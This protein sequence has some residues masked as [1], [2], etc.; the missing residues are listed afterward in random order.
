M[1]EP[2]KNY[3]SFLWRVKIFVCF[4]FHNIF[5]FQA[6]YCEELGIVN[7]PD[8]NELDNLDLDKDGIL[9]LEEANNY[10]LVSFLRIGFGFPYF[11]RSANSA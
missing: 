9:E 10:K 8:E 1:I 2:P 4:I 7:C 6:Q 5:L 11:G 3:C